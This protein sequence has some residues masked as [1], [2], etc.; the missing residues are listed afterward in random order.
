M[1]APEVHDDRPVDHRRPPCPGRARP[2]ARPCP[3]R[4]AASA[5]P[6]PAR[7]SRGRRGPRTARRPSAAPGSATRARAS[8]TSRHEPRPRAETGVSAMALD[9][10]PARA[11]A[12][13]RALSSAV[14]ALQVAAGPS[15][16]GPGAWRPARPP[17]GGRGRSCPGRPRPAGRCGRCPGGPACRSAARAARCPSS[18]TLPASGRSWPQMQLNSVVLPAPLGPTSPTLSPRSTAK[19][20]SSTAVIPPNAL[21]TPGHQEQR[22]GVA[23]PRSTSRRGRRRRRHRRAGA[24]RR[25]PGTALRHRRPTAP[26]ERDPPAGSAGGWPCRV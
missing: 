3:A 6:R 11:P 15:T 2:A 25:R 22:V 12:S 5:A 19:V 7:G 13:T 21:A 1:T 10:R 20:T 24:G 14:G 16:A 23:E 18:S 4:A 8:S 17:S 26:S 9:A